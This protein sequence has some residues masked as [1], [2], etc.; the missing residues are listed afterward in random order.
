MGDLNVVSLILVAI[1]FTYSAKM[2]TDA[3]AMQF[4]G[5]KLWMAYFGQFSHRSAH[6]HTKLHPVAEALQ[7]AGVMISAKDHRSHHTP[8][9]ETDFC[10]IGVMNPLLAAARTVTTNRHLWLL[11]FL[12][13]SV[14]DIKAQTYLCSAFYL[15]QPAGD[16]AQAPDDSV[17][18]A[19]NATS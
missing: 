11:A 14:F 13:M 12:A 6:T 19:T 9:H 1:H 8:P 2:G 10:L 7:S 15:H 16:Y 3:L 17:D 4:T 18:Q 5:F